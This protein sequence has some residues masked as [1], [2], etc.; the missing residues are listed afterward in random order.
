MAGAAM[1]VTV[2]APLIGAALLASAWSGPLPTLARGSFAAHMG[3]HLLVVAAAA[4]LLALTVLQQRGPRS[5]ALRLM[6]PLP[7]SLVELVV[8]W[9]WHVPRLHHAARTA[10]AP[11]V[12]EQALFVGAGVLFW[13]SIVGAVSDD[14]GRAAGTAVV[15][16]AL[17]LAHMTLL[18]ALLAL[19]PRPLYAHGGDA[20]AALADQQRGGALMLVVSA[21]VYLSAGVLVGQ[22]L[23]RPVAPIAVARP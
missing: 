5:R 12:V 4:P 20:A 14:R 6:S 18:G 1:P 13:L 2:W 19:G 3:L 11:F 23:L 21:T 22:R 7:A 10:F 8:V 9:A 16:L 15:A 17:T